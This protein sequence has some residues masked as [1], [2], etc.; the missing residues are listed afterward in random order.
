[1]HR[2]PFVRYR[3]LFR[4]QRT[5]ST[6]KFPS[7]KVSRLLRS[8]APQYQHRSCTIEQVT[9]HN[10]I[11]QQSS[12]SDYRSPRRLRRSIFLNARIAA[13]Q[14][15]LTRSSILYVLAAS[16]RPR[17]QLVLRTARHR[18]DS[19]LSLPTPPPL[20]NL[21]TSKEAAAA[22]DWLVRF[23]GCPIPRAAVDIAFSRSS[24]PGGQVCLPSPPFA[25]RT[26][27]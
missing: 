24:G 23:R 6:G 9:C 8:F 17:V 27:R 19:R 18:T 4:K 3:H 13:V 1:M 21:E 5:R 20:S 14:M 10:R 26:N 11:I 2:R 16:S 15:L 22:R 12:S 25:V 7:L